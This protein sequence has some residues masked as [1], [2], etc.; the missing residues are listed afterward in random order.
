[1]NN[2]TSKIEL[3]AKLEEVNSLDA[4][5]AL[6]KIFDN[7]LNPAFGSLPKKEVEIILFQVLQELKVF[8]KQPDLYS[9]LSSLRVTRAKARNLLYESNLRLD[10]DLEHELVEALKN[11]VLLKDNDKVC[12]EID[13]PLLIDHLKHTLKEMDHITDG[14]FSPD[15]VKLTPK[16]FKALLNTKFARVSKK[17]INKALVACGAESEVTIKSVLTGVLK[18]VGNKVASDAG[19]QVGE[20]LGDYLGDIFSKGYSSVSEFIRAKTGKD[21]S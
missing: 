7:Y 18:K 6:I 19:D 2:P 15:L 9:L 5:A 21:V 11:P 13:N 10:V 17:E 12:L 20:K 1:M 16:A 14:S 4:K 3:L 8:D